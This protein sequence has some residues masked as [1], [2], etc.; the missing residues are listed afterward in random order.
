MLLLT[1][2]PTLLITM[3]IKQTNLIYQAI[4]QILIRKIINLELISINPKIQN[5]TILRRKMVIK[6]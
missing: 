2:L 6:V 3:I 4:M 5:F 1:P